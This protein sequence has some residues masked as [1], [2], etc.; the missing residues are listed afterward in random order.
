MTL[1]SY[2]PLAFQFAM[3][4]FA[5]I[6]EFVEMQRF[7][8]FFEHETECQENGSPHCWETHAVV[9]DIAVGGIPVCVENTIP[10]GSCESGKPDADRTRRLRGQ[11]RLGGE[12]ER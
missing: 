7:P 3:D 9:E 11:P 10:L 4:W 6:F 1:N 8:S 2:H 5:W 12:Q